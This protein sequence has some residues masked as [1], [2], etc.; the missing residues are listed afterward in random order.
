M[1][2]ATQG[3]HALL[4]AYPLQGHVIPA[5]HLAINLASRGFTITFVNS[6]SI[7]HQT[8]KANSSCGGEEDI[9]TTARGSGLDIRYATVSDGLPVEHKRFSNLDQFMAAML[10][11]Q[12]AHVEELVSKV[13]RCSV[14]PVTC[15]IADS[16]FVWPSAIAKKFGLPYVSFWTEPALVFTLYYHTDLLTKNGHFACHGN[17]LK[18]RGGIYTQF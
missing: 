14:P 9:F 16:F 7:H 17:Q 18:K 6:Q 4:F 15:L 3:P 2:M 13:V 8:S 10:H 5:V 11:V 12:S 1:S